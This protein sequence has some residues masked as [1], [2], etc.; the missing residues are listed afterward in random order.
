MSY[1]NFLRRC[2]KRSTWLVGWR[3]L[4]FPKVCN[5]CSVF[6][7]RNFFCAGME[8]ERRYS[9]PR[10]RFAMVKMRSYF[11]AEEQVGNQHEEQ[12]MNDYLPY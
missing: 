8:L 9:G 12:A 5:E 6:S 4:A 7:P 10:R 2:Q 3:I 11:G 1:G